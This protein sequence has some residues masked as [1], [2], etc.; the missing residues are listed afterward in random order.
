M[1]WC[2]RFVRPSPKCDGEVARGVDG[3][4]LGRDAVFFWDAMQV[5]DLHRP[6]ITLDYER[7]EVG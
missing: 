2:A 4:P 5:S 1:T 7:V 3:R 6:A